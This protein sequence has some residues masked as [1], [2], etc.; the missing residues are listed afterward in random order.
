MN[1]VKTLM[2]KQLIKSK[3]V[4]E[5]IE[6]NGNQYPSGVIDLLTDYYDLSIMQLSDS[7]TEDNVKDG[8]NNL[9]LICQYGYF[10]LIMDKFSELKSVI[11]NQNQAGQTALHYALRYQ[12]ENMS[13][14][15]F[16]INSGANYL[17]KDNTLS[18]PLMI[19]KYHSANIIDDDLTRNYRHLYNQLVK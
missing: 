19:I 18:S 3:D 17:I 2:Q 8:V 12:M 14:I 7:L 6:S 9:M 10:P 11:N 5:I 15:V 1:K 16:L 4:L 13:M